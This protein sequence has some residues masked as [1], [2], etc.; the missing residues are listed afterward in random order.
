MKAVNIPASVKYIGY[1]AFEG[2]GIEVVT[3]E[4][5]SALTEIMDGAFSA[6]SLLTRIALPAGVTEIP[7]RLFEYCT[8]LTEFT[9][10]TIAKYHAFDEALENGMIRFALNDGKADNT[11]AGA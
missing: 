2:S 6:C 10:D 7:A 5:N 8:S 1:G 4:E 9:L 11:G 3:F